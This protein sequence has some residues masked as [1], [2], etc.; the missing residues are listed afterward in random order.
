MLN[1]RFY[2]LCDIKGIQEPTM[3]FGPEK[4]HIHLE[5]LS[6]GHLSKSEG[7]QN[8]LKKIRLVLDGLMEIHSFGGD[9]WCIVDFKKENSTISNFFDEFEPF[10]IESA[11]ILKLL[12]DWYAFLVKWENNEIPGIIHPNSRIK[13]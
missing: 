1:Y 4:N 8:E 10:K 3:K 6:F 2:I 9:E 5:H 7:V 12:E 11:L 13:T